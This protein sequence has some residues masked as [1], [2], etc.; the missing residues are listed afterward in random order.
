MLFGLLGLFN[1]DMESE[2]KSARITVLVYLDATSRR[3]VKTTRNF[4]TDHEPGIDV[5]CVPDA[6]QLRYCSDKAK[7]SQ[8][9]HRMPVTLIWIKFGSHWR[10]SMNLVSNLNC[11]MF[12]NCLR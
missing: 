9:A 1:V 10:Y 8:W 4:T 7:G 11:F 12:F 2:L 6:S 3:L 5:L